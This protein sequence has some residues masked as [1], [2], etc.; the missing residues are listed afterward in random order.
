MSDTKYE[1]LFEDEGNIFGGSPESKY[2]DVIFNANRSVCEN[3]L[4]RQI[5]RQAVMEMIL[6][7]KLGTDYFDQIDKLMWNDTPELMTKVKT[8]YIE[9]MGNVLTQAE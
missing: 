2:I 7:E 6:E 5:K 1:A 3:E 4:A 9:C 8:L